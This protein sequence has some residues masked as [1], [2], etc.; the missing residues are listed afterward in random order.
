MVSPSLM[1]DA[2]ALAT[3]AVTVPPGVYPAGIDFVGLDEP[4]IDKVS[5]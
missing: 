5:V 1:L 3:S 2:N 4:V